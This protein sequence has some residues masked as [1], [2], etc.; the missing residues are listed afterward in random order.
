MRSR[1]KSAPYAELVIVMGVLLPI[2]ACTWANPW[3]KPV[4]AAG[5]GESAEVKKE[6]P[7]VKL[8]RDEQLIFDKY[9]SNPGIGTG[10]SD[11]SRA[12]ESRLGYK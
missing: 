8:S 12:V 1:G 10:L 3:Q 4:A 11:Q 7:K 5:E 9:H 6:M 2:S